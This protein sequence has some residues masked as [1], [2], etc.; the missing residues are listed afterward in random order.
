MFQYSSC[1]RSSP[2]VFMGSLVCYPP[3][4]ANLHCTMNIHSF[5]SK[6]NNFL[7]FAIQMGVLYV[8]FHQEKGRDGRRTRWEGALAMV[9]RAGRAFP[10]RQSTLTRRASKPDITTSGTHMPDSPI[11]HFLLFTTNKVHHLSPLAF[12]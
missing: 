8:F 2:S 6:C 7:H 12:K 5:P 3:I 10:P 4:E 1:N 9:S 11:N